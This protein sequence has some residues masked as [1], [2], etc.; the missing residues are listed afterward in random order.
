M[1]LPT[2][3]LTFHADASVVTD[4]WKTNAPFATHPADNEGFSFWDDVEHA[5]IVGAGVAS[6]VWRSGTPLMLLPCTDF[7]GSS[8]Y[9]QL[10]NNA[11]TVNK[12]LSDIITNSAATLLVSFYAEGITANAAAAYDNDCIFGDAGG[13]FGLHLKN[14]ADPRLLFYNWDGNEDTLSLATTINASHVAMM[15]HEGSNIYG[16]IDGGSESSVASGNTSTMTGNPQIARGVGA[17]YFNGRIGEIAIWNAAL[18]GSDLSDAIS[19]FTSKWLG[20]AGAMLRHPGMS[21]MR[22]EM[23]G[24]LIG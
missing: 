2:T 9:F 23:A 10:K 15:R 21:G 6:P 19:Y 13:F 16:S 5:D 18:T 1:A 11:G 24:G 17:K 20:V 4:L 22:N 7:D 12:A 14:S 3:G 8:Q